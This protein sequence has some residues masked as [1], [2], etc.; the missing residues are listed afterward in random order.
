ML[1]GKDTRRGQ[2]LDLGLGNQR[3]GCGVGDRDDHRGH[4]A[5]RRE[6]ALLVL[7]PSLGHAEHGSL[8][9]GTTARV[10]FL[11]LVLPLVLAAVVHLVH[12][13]R[14]RQE[15]LV[16]VNHRANLLEHAPRGLVSDTK[17]PFQLL[18]RNATTSARHE[19]DRVEPELEPGGRSLEDRGFHRV[20]MVPA[21][22]ALIRRPTRFAVVL[23]DL[24]ALRA[25]DTVRVE[26]R[27]EVGEARG[28]VGEQFVPL[29][30]GAS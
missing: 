22:L 7:D 13:D 12:L 30:A 17:F 15:R 29:E 5:V 24:L 27:D 23:R 19:V 28:V 26:L 10:R 1:V 21:E 25:V 14:S 2:H 4:L 8:G 20:L 11:D 6:L 9:D 16:L 18:G 3:V